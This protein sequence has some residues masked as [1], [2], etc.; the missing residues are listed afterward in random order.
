MASCELQQI[1][2]FMH[3]IHFMRILVKEF[4]QN[5]ICHLDLIQLSP[6][7]SSYGSTRAIVA[8]VV[9]IKVCYEV[10]GDVPP[11]ETPQ[12]F[13]HEKHSSAGTSCCFLFHDSQWFPFWSGSIPSFTIMRLFVFVSSR[14]QRSALWSINKQR[15]PP[16]QRFQRATGDRVSSSGKHCWE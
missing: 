8:I 10:V 14:T 15:S 12:V 5:N 3:F 1:H 13:G 16:F 6:D 11:S 7:H 4:L 9:E 2:F